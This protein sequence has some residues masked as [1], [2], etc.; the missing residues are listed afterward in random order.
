[1]PPGEPRSHSQRA[2]RTA[3]SSAA[4]GPLPRSSRAP[5]IRSWPATR[6]RTTVTP[7]RTSSTVSAARESASV[8]PVRSRRSS[9]TSPLRSLFEIVKTPASYSSLRSVQ[10]RLRALQRRHRH[11]AS[12]LVEPRRRRPRA[13]RR[14]DL[15]SNDFLVLDDSGQSRTHNLFYLPANATHLLFRYEV[16]D[17]DATNDLRISLSGTT[18]ATISLASTTSGFVSAEAAI[19]LALRNKVHTLTFEIV[20]GAVGSEVNVDTVR[21]TGPRQLDADR[22][23]RGFGAQQRPRQ[24]RR[25]V[26][27]T[28]RSRWPQP[29]SS[30]DRRRARRGQRVPHA[31]ARSDQRGEE[32]PLW[33]RSDRRRAGTQF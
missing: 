31:A 11:R 18:L 24:Y 32:L 14:R 5:S 27:R 33:R 7:R 20:Y 30:A 29:G 2:T 17:A 15:R 25:N 19:P 3:P 16:D 26:R 22:W 4:R 23:K 8:R 21:F 1:M 9:M 6:P 12:R 13:L 28:A 10:R